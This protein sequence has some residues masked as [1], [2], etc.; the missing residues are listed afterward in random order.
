[1]TKLYSIVSSSVCLG[2]NVLDVNKLAYLWNFHI[3]VDVLR[4]NHC[5]FVRHS[6]FNAK[7]PCKYVCE[8]LKL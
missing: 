4:V 8:L 6:V 5:Y 1:M 7:L 3:Y 2:V